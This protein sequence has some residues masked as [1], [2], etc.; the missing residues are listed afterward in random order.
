MHY[1]HP[2]SIELELYRFV[3]SDY[4]GDLDKRRSLTDF[5]FVFWGNIIFWKSNLQ[6]I[7]A[8]STTETEFIALIE[9]VKEAI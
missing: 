2:K 4:A 9:A 5:T 7:V 8:L 6:S 1:R 3:D